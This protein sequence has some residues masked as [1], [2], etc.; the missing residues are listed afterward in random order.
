MLILYNYI[1]ILMEKYVITG[2]P[3]AGKTT[4]L[5]ELRRLG[6]QIV[7]EAARMIIEHGWGDPRKDLASFQRKVVALQLSLEQ[8]V[9]AAA[10]CDRGLPDT[11]AY[12]RLGNIEPVEL[13][14]HRYAGV[15]LID[16]VPFQNDSVRWE[17]KE[18][19]RIIHDAIENAYRDLDYAVIKV[20]VLSPNERAEFIVKH[21]RGVL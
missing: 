13:P 8:M 9:D 14:T 15:F 16:P 11:I 18:Q 5:N 10:F 19:A 7:P 20:P 2:G 21:L 6:Y 1:Y 3:G 4:T 17:S 12:S